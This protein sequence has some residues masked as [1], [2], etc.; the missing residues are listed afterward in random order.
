MIHVSFRIGYV[1][2]VGLDPWGVNSSP[3]INRTIEQSTIQSIT[4]S[5]S[6]DE[7]TH[8]RQTRRKQPLLLSTTVLS[9]I[10]SKKCPKY[11]LPPPQPYRSMIY[12]YLG[13]SRRVYFLRCSTSIQLLV[14]GPERILL[15]DFGRFLT[16][17]RLSHCLV[18]GAENW[19]QGGREMKHALQLP[20]R[21]PKAQTRCDGC[22][23]SNMYIP[24]TR[25]CPLHALRFAA[26]QCPKLT[27]GGEQMPNNPEGLAMIP[28]VESK[29]TFEPEPRCRRAFSKSSARAYLH[30]RIPPFPQRILKLQGT[31]RRYVL[32]AIPS[33]EMYRP[34]A[35]G[36]TLIR[37]S[38]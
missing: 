30:P 21:P 9:R 19:S 1:H 35:V 27:A 29:Q 20:K 37:T 3:T 18:T 6:M 17:R 31:W 36:T 10:P 14:H 11:P 4:V 23:K 32:C 12:T 34:R 25:L 13:H 7:F 26:W 16:V 8:R 22:S 28:T 38:D 24:H 15:G 33:R 5:A 2:H